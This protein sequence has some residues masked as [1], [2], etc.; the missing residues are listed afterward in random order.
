MRWERD[1]LLKYATAVISSA[2]AAFNVAVS[3]TLISYI[4]IS[5]ALCSTRTAVHTIVLRTYLKYAALGSE[6]TSVWIS[7]SLINGR[8][9]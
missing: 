7:P 2:C 6:S 3:A 8:N 9:K 1:N 5:T 4:S